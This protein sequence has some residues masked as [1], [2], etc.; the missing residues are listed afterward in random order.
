VEEAARSVGRIPMKLADGSLDWRPLL[1]ADTINESIIARAA[2]KNPQ[3]A[4]KLQEAE[5][6]RDLHATVAA[7]ATAEV[8]TTLG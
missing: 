4:T 6:I 1:P 3:G 2:A 7:L 8:R 5:E